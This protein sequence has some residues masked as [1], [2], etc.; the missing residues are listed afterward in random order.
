MPISLAL[1]NAEIR[2]AEL[3]L[4]E[5]PIRPSPARRL[6]DDLAHKH[7]L[8]ADIVADRRDH[9]HIGEK[10]DRGERRTAGRD[11]MHEF[12]GDVRGIA[13]RAAVAHREQPAVVAVDVGDG[14]GRGDQRWCAGAEEA[15]LVSRLSRDFSATESEAAASTLIG[16]LGLAV[17]KRIKARKFLFVGHDTLSYRVA[18]KPHRF[19]FGLRFAEFGQNLHG[20]R[21]FRLIDPAHREADVNQHPITDTG[22]QPGCSSETM[23]AMLTCRL[24]PLTSTVASFLAAS[25][26]L[27]MRPGMPRHM[28]FSLQWFVVLILVEQLCG[29][30]RGLAECQA[31]VA[32]W[33]C[34]CA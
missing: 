22:L 5:M 26:I 12:D 31:A 34:R 9:R 21:D 32:G 16:V 7:V 23:Q 8:E 28:G 29:G 20:L 3:P 4:V 2:F 11:G 25:S 15:S 13:A 14:L 33:N 6:G 17:Q 30:D 1:T 19:H 24:M 27:T 18:R 10:V